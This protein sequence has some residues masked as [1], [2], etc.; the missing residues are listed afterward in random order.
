MPRTEITK[1][2]IPQTFSIAETAEILGCSQ[3]TIRRRIA[4]GT[5][6]ARRFGPR[7]IRVDARSLAGSCMPIPTAS[8]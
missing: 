2:D 1:A 3:V 6:V 8:A 7:L 5:I 4:D